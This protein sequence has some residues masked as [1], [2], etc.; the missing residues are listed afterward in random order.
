MGSNVPPITPS[1]RRDCTNSQLTA[2]GRSAQTDDS[3]CA[4]RSSE[5]SNA[6]RSAR[7]TSRAYSTHRS[8]RSTSG[9]TTSVAWRLRERASYCVDGQVY[10]A[11]PAVRWAVDLGL[12][13]APDQIDPTAADSSDG[14][15]CVPALAGLAAPWS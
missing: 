9:L 15:F 14:V 1:L 12:L 2:V 4:P 10:T 11:A 7:Y 6:A 5:T 3:R 13:A 8:G